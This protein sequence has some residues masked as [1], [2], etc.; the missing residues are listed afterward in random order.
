[1][2]NQ[3]HGCY[4]SEFAITT[5]AATTS[6]FYEA[7][8]EGDVSRALTL[9]RPEIFYSVPG[10]E[11]SAAITSAQA[12]SGLRC[13][14]RRRSR[15]CGSSPTRVIGEESPTLNFPTWRFSPS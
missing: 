8:T 14:H 5:D 6:E 15:A 9:C 7:V 2:Q 13:A 12:Q 11:R 1:M 4:H 3:F 10:A